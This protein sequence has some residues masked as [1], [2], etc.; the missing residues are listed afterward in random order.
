MQKS[1]DRNLG[2]PAP[3]ED[4]DQNVEQLKARR[5]G[6][7]ATSTEAARRET[8]RREAKQNRHRSA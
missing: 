6:T 7:L 2:R 5:R 4:K 3:N 8:E 1:A